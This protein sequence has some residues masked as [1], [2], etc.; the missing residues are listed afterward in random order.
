MRNKGG[1]GGVFHEEDRLFDWAKG[2][3]L[4]FGGEE[5]GWD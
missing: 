5:W 3:G 1:G 2:T 4:Y